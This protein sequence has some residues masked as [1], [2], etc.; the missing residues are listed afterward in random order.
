MHLMLFKDELADATN[1]FAGS[2]AS[3][4]SCAGVCVLFAVESV[5]CESSAVTCVSLDTFDSLLPL[6]VKPFC[7]SAIDVDV[8]C[9]A[10]VD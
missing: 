2:A 6:A 1:V 5:F 3:L 4:L 7:E 10:D 9:C 8:C